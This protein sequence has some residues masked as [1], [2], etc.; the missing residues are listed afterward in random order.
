MSQRPRVARASLQTCLAIAFGFLLVLAG[1][2][3]ADD[4]A[5]SP[6]ETIIQG[7]RDDVRRHIRA[8]EQRQMSNAGDLS[9]PARTAVTQ[10][11]TQKRKN[12]R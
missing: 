11:A 6:R 3:K 8:S 1:H 7:V 12:D 2:A 4:P 5:M 9:G 10:H